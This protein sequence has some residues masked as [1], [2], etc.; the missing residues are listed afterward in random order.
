MKKPF[1][2]IIAPVKNEEDGIEYFLKELIVVLKEFEH[3]IIIIDDGSTDQTLQK[4]LEQQKNNPN[5]KIIE[6]SRNFGKEAALIAGLDFCQGDVA[7]C[8]DSDLQHP[9]QLIL[10]M[11]EEWENGYDTVSTIRQERKTDGIIKRS[12]ASLFYKI[13]NAIAATKIRI[14]EGD[15]RLFDRKC[16]NA[17]K[18]LKEKTRFNKGLF[19]WI[20]FKTAYVSYILPERLYGRTQWNYKKLIGLAMDGIFSFSNIP[21]RIF[22]YL[23]FVISSMSFLYALYIILKTVIFGIDLPGY[24]SIITSIFLIGGVIITGIG[25]LGEYIAR[26]FIESKERPIYLVRKYH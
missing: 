19:N 6:F 14:G 18:E 2:S 26:I 13:Y 3:E 4:L 5:L 1:L 23:G 10:Q 7:I 16:I 24:P 15:F 25:I 12:L 9:P 11:I 21:L 20:G 17:L 22:I 8:M